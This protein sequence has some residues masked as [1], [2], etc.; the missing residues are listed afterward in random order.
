MKVMPVFKALKVVI[1]V[2]KLVQGPKF[3]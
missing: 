2:E 3:C 1:K